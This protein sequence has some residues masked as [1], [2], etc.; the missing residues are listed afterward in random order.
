MSTVIR[1][2]RPPRMNWFSALTSR[3]PG[4]RD[5]ETVPHIA[6]EVENIRAHDVREYQQTCGFPQ[7]DVLPLPLPHILATPLHIAIATHQDFPLP[8]MGL[9]HVSNSILQHRRIMASESLTITC[10]CEGHRPHPRGALV[11]MQTEILSGQERVWESQSTVLSS[12][13]PGGGEKH[14]PPAFPQGTPDRSTDWRLPEDLG[15]KYGAISRDKN[16]IHMY[17]WTAK[18]F[19][20]QRHIIHGMWLLARAMSELDEDAGNGPL[21]VDIHF[22]RPVFLPGTVLFQSSRSGP[23]I[24]FHLTNP[25][26]GKIHAQGGVRILEP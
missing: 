2:E 10:S 22:I 21:Q 11:D 18:L 12:A 8:A 6:V 13:A 16:P 26:N 7:S 15:R 23:D 1:L 20:F 9:V 17:A 5:N 25:K 4:L 14:I 19:G 3:K 24:A